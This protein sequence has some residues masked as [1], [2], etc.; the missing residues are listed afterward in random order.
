MAKYSEMRYWVTVKFGRNIHHRTMTNIK[1]S[2]RAVAPRGEILKSEMDMSRNALLSILDA[3][4]RRFMVRRGLPKLVKPDRS[5]AVIHGIRSGAMRKGVPNNST[6]ARNQATGENPM[7]RLDDGRS[8]ARLGRP[9]LRVCAWTLRADIISIKKNRGE[10]PSQD[11]WKSC[12]YPFRPG[13]RRTAMK[14]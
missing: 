1:Y 8:S 14:T 7:V 4:M 6:I 12:C 11:A 9:G 5:E 13:I 10:V 2:I 3:E